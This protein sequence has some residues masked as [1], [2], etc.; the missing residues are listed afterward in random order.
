MI[1]YSQ[2]VWA[3]LKQLQQNLLNEQVEI[4]NYH[5]FTIYD[6]KERQI[7]AA[8]FEERVLHHALMNVCH[9]Y[10]E[11]FQIYDSY[12]TRIGK[13]TFRALDKAAIF[14]RS[15]AYYLKMDIRKYF[16]SIDHIILFTQLERHFKDAALLRLFRQIIESYHTQPGKGV[17]IGNLTSQYF[18]NHYLALTDHF[19]KERLGVKPY[20]RY[21][22]DFVIWH[23][24][25]EALQSIQQNITDFLTTHLA[26][27]LKTSY[28]N[29]TTHGLPFLG[30]RL[31]PHKRLLSRRSKVRF[32][33][34]MM[35]LKAAW[36]VSEISE[37]K[38][39]QQATALLDFVRKAYTKKYRKQYL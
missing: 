9:E 24:E 14:Q 15:Y 32:R 34:K 38:M 33:T 29:K 20:V 31:F 7:C 17:P 23:S 5:Y 16:D 36:E 12:A 30:F 27:S 28:I 25:L 8:S 18:A 13:G 1:A 11:K 2:D 22:D 26:L 35:Q 19:I 21:M 37:A 6:P 10:F 39:Q 3:R 4:G